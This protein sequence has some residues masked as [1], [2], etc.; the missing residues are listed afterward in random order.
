[1]TA[2][3][4]VRRQTLRTEPPHPVSGSRL[5]R[6]G[7]SGDSTR[8]EAMRPRL[9][10]QEER[11]EQRWR[12]PLR[13]R[14][15]PRPHQPLPRLHPLLSPALPG[16]PRCCLYYQTRRRQQRPKGARGSPPTRPD[17]TAGAATEAAASHRQPP[18]RWRHCPWGR[19]CTRG[20]C[21]CARAKRTYQGP[22]CLG[23]LSR[24]RGSPFRPVG[25]GRGVTHQRQ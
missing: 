15:A 13:W 7:P 16:R 12:R 1:M 18:V 5:H 14:R 17:R 21:T 25:A 19:M 2:G 10:W 24:L 22:K 11:P 6:Q 20:T 9:A 3:P 4:L 23:G 8:P